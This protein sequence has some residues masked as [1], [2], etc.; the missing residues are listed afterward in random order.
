MKNNQ[1]G[2]NETNYNHMNIYT[3]IN[4]QKKVL[5]CFMCVSHKKFFLIIF[6]FNQK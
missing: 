3:Y 2:K 1:Q 6:F 4:Q 5:E